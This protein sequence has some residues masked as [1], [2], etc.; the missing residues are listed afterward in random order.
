MEFF[1]CENE[2]FEPEYNDIGDVYGCGILVNTENE[3]AIFFTGNG[4][5]MGQFSS[6]CICIDN[7]FGLR[8]N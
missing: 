1:D 7:P 3:L 4:T 2:S 5:L 8:E 6:V